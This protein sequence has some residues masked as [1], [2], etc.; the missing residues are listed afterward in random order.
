M[1]H[2]SAMVYADDVNILDENINTI[3]KNREDLLEANWG[4]GLV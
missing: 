3:K 4:R 1:A 2:T